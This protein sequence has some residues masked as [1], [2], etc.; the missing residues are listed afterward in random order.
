MLVL[1]TRQQI[2]DIQWNSL[3]NQSVGEYFYALTWYLDIVSPDWEALVFLQNGKYEA[4]MP[5]PVAKLY[6]IAYLKQPLFCQQLGIFANPTCTVSYT[7]FLE[8]LYQKFSYIAEYSFNTTNL[9]IATI[10][11]NSKNDSNFRT[12]ICN[13][14]LVNLRQTPENIYKNYTKDRKTNLKRALSA[15]N[16]VIESEDIAPLVAIFRA[17]TEQKIKGG[18][19][20]KAYSLLQQVYEALAARQMAKLYYTIQQKNHQ[21]TIES[22]VLLAFSQRKIIYL[23]NAGLEKYRKKNGRTLL[24]HHTIEKYAN[25]NYDYFDFESPEVEEIANFYQS[26]GAKAFPYLQI[27]YNNL[28]FW[29]EIPKKIRKLLYDSNYCKL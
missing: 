8:L 5:L 14:H 21:I 26:F 7:K 16:Q 20:V 15:S 3:I 23:F 19:D 25:S 27:H 29:I 6:G 18:V 28:P 10:Y 9:E 4:V 11:K 17:E 24:I 22:G 1:L 2:D 12:K 13:T